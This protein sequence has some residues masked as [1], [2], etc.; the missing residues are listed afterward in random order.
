MSSKQDPEIVTKLMKQWEKGSERRMLQ[1]GMPDRTRFKDVFFLQRSTS[2]AS[3]VYV[4]R[5]QAARLAAEGRLAQAE[6]G[7][8]A[9]QRTIRDLQTTLKVTKASEEEGVVW[10][11]GI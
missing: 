9:L 8:H 2:Q 7:A 6:E 10:M 4:F 1:R 5:E 11:E 3:Y